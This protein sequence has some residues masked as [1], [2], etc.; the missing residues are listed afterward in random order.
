MPPRRGKG[1][2]SSSAETHSD[3][4]RSVCPWS[5]LGLD[6]GSGD[7]A[8]SHSAARVVRCEMGHSSGLGGANPRHGSRAS[9]GTFSQRSACRA[10][11][12]RPNDLCSCQPRRSPSGGVRP[13]QRGRSKSVS[14]SELRTGGGARVR[15][16]ARVPLWYFGGG[17]YQTA[18]AARVCSLATRRRGQRVSGRRCEAVGCSLGGGAGL[19]GW[20]RL[21]RVYARSS[22]ARPARSGGLDEQLYVAARRLV[23][24]VHAG[25]G[26]GSVRSATRLSLARGQSDGSAPDRAWR[27]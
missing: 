22:R 19:S 17:R 10:G 15:F 18:R 9:G 21:L 23:S 16:G 4:T 2:V 1:V 24:P 26:M 25:G 3:H 11:A 14:P 12:V 13:Q 7:V 6:R 20:A 8:F 27:R 5:S